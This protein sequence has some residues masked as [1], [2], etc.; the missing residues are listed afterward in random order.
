M[1]ILKGDI[2]SF[3]ADVMVTA[4]NT[5]LR[6]GGGVDGAVH[7]AAGPELLESLKDFNGCETGCAVMTRAFNLNAK[8]VIH[9]VGPIYQDGNN[10][11]AKLLAAAY[12]SSIELAKS[13]DAKSILF[14]AISTGVYG[15]PLQEA[16][17]IAVNSI[18]EGCNEHNFY[19]DI[20]MV[21]FD[22]KAFSL[23]SETLKA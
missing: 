9:A 12:K 19:G 4:A 13:V 23:L 5:Y 14:P 7:Q 8:Y 6:G 1:R 20:A 17:S 2:T 22:E 16:L 21:C 11:E 3:K 15:Y 18:N 10:E